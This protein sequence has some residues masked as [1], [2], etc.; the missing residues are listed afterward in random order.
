MSRAFAF[1]TL[2]SLLFYGCSC[3]E[4]PAG[5]NDTGGVGTNDGT[6]GGGDGST[7]ARDGGFDPDGNPINPD[8]TG[9]DSGLGP[10]DLGFDS[11][12]NPIEPDGA[13]GDDSGVGPSDLGFDSDGN[14]IEPDSGPAG[15]DSGPVGADAS[16]D[17][18]ALEEPLSRFCTGMGSVVVVGEGGACA[19]E[20]AENTFRFALCAC[21]G[22]EVQSNLELDA[23]DSTRG[24]YGAS[25]PGGGTNIIADGHLGLNSALNMTGKLTV[26]G[27]GFIGG[28]GI[29]VGPQSLVSANLYAAGPANQPNADTTVGRNALIGGNI[30]GRYVVVGDLYIPAGATFP[31]T[32]VMGQVIRR[33]VPRTTPC[34]CAASEILNIAAL[35]TYGRTHNDNDET[36]AVTSTTWANDMGPDRLELPCGRFYLTRVIHSG[37]L[38]IRA[39]DRTV[40]YVD[41]DFM[42]GGNFNLELA[43]GAELDLFVRGSLTVGAAARFGSQAEPSAVRTYVGGTSTITLSAS[44]IFGGNLYAPRAH[45][46][47]SASSN[48]YGSLF[49]KSVEFAGSA[50][51]HYDSAIRTASQTCEEPVDGGPGVD[52]GRDGGVVGDTGIRDTGI[53]D[54]GLAGDGGFRDA[55]PDSGIN[56]DT[57]IRPDTGVPPDSGVPQCTGCFQCGDQSCIN[58]Q[59]APCRDDFDC[60]APYV[61]NGMGQCVLPI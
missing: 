40:L 61:C 7:G 57:G 24:A 53:R 26:M 21:R 58:G 19:G 38:T 20:I 50:N 3:D 54:T 1:A 4:D 11:D 41:G 16:R 10:S 27:S 15:G 25:L 13:T 59:C 9:G 12:G 18:G 5:G 44:A 33:A 47:F 32:T 2:L 22:V 28:G 34:P 46:V 23:F 60:C 6:T 56:A 17:G 14:A 43:P 35:T 52:A 8:A 36:M 37:S 48:L 29:T 55:T 42:I 39:L 51:V 45:V 31:Q 49:A 30:T